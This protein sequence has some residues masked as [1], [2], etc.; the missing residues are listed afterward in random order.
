MNSLS[1]EDSIL[2]IHRICSSSPPPQHE[3]LASDPAAFLI[4]SE[5][6]RR[7]T[8]RSDEEAQ[9]VVDLVREA[10]RC[11][12]EPERIGIITPFRAHAARIR[13]VLG[14]ADSAGSL[15]RRVLVDSSEPAGHSSFFKHPAAVGVEDGDSAV[16]K[17]DFRCEGFWIAVGHRVRWLDWREWDGSSVEPELE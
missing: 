2:A 9:L 11:G 17:G 12:M 6:V 4:C 7:T 10:V 3:A 13:Q 16:F 8:V 1:C 5:N 14:I 15:R